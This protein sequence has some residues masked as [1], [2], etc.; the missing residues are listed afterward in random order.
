MR[1]IDLPSELHLM[2]FAELEDLDDALYFASSC[3]Y[4]SRLYRANNSSIAKNMIVSRFPFSYFQV[5]ALGAAH[6]LLICP[7]VRRVQLSQ[8]PSVPSDAEAKLCSQTQPSNYYLHYTDVREYISSDTNEYD[9]HLSK[10]I[11]AENDVIRMYQ[12]YGKEPT[13]ERR[14]PKKDFLRCENTKRHVD[15]YTDVV[16]NEICT[17]WQKIRFLRELYQDSAVFAEFED[18]RCHFLTARTVR[19]TYSIVSPGFQHNVSTTQAFSGTSDSYG[20][21]FWANLHKTLCLHSLAIATRK[22]AKATELDGLNVSKADI[23]LTACYAW[24][25]EKLPGVYSVL[26]PELRIQALETWDFIYYFLLRKLVPPKILSDWIMACPEDSLLQECDGSPAFDHSE[27]WSYFMN[28]FRW[29]LHPKDV[30]AA[31]AA[32]AWEPESSFA[33]DKERFMAMRGAF[34]EEAVGDMDWY[35]FHK[36]QWC[37][38]ALGRGDCEPPGDERSSWWD[39]HRMRNGSPFHLSFDSDV[40]LHSSI[41]KQQAL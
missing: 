23:E 11:E 36:R 41:L 31:I 4:L 22:L 39:Q 37:V 25:K 6:L 12:Q 32:K 34:D 40:I 33:P 5:G 17:R 26:S 28:L 9:L 29:I 20:D 14:P 13:A 38:N 24:A 8:P 21:Y 19:D 27:R 2:V 10:F 7:E 1:F 30:V 35:T 18:F 16:I 3:S 15:E